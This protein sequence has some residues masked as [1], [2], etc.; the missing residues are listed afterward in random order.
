MIAEAL[1][2][3]A[4]GA[5]PAQ[6]ALPAAGGVLGVLFSVAYVYTGELALPIGLHLTWNAVQGP[7]YGFPVSGWPITEGSILR[8]T[9]H[10]PTW[11]T[12]GTFGPEAGLLGL[13]AMAVGVPGI[14]WAGWHWRAS[15]P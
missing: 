10:G 2:E 7:V 8:T 12:G 3:N 11:L 13:G 5:A 6:A 14:V 4:V 1:E 15:H 9:Q